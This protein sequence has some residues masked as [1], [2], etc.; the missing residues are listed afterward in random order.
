MRLRPETR[1]RACV[2][3]KKLSSSM[4]LRTRAAVA[5]LTFSESLM[6]RETVAVET[7][8]LFATSFMFMR[9]R[10][11]FQ[12]RKSAIVAMILRQ[13]NFGGVLI[14]LLGFACL[15]CVSIVS[16]A[17]D[18][19]PPIPVEIRDAPFSDIRWRFRTVTHRIPVT[20]PS[21]YEHH[22]RIDSFV[23]AFS[24]NRLGLN[25]TNIKAMPAN[26]SDC[27]LV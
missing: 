7:L 26:R 2:F 11:D 27:V 15:L 17:Y 3:G 24:D 19:L 4:A 23:H 6:V 25:V 9:T 12:G 20:E 16:R 8:A 21:V 22:F 10:E 18:K 13:R 14:C 1:V 5:G